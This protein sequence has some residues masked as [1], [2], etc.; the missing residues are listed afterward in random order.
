MRVDEL[1]GHRRAARGEHHVVAEQHRERLLSDE[2]LGHEH[3]VTEPEL[4]AL[5]DERD[6]ADLTDA[7]DRP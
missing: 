7:P 5:M 2:V 3:R 1:P 6:R 4:L